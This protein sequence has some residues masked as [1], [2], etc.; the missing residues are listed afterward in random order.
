MAYGFIRTTVQTRSKG[1][2]ATGALCYRLGLAA[3]STIL[4]KDGEPRHFDFTRRTGIAATGYAAPPGTD[5]SWRDPLRWAKRIEAVDR[6]RNS[7]QFRDDVVA[8]PVELVEAGMAEEAVQ[9]YADRLAAEHRTVVHFAIHEPD[10]GGLNHHAHVLYP[11]RHVVGVTFAKKRDREQDNPKPGEPDLITRHKAIWSEICR[12][13]GVELRWSSPTPGHHLGPKLCAVKRARLVE[14]TQESVRETIAVSKP[15]EIAPDD[16]ALR[17]VAVIATGVNEGLTVGA[18]LRREL[19]QIRRGHPAPRPV[20]APTGWL[21]EVLQPA[22]VPEVLPARGKAPEV[23]PPA[24]AHEVLPPTRPSPEVLSARTGAPEVLPPTVA[25]EVLPRTSIPEV[26]PP[27]RKAARVLHPVRLPEVLPVVRS[28]AAVS[29]PRAVAEAMVVTRAEERFP[30]E[31]A[32]TW[33]EVER[34]LERQRQTQVH[35]HARATAK[36]LCDRAK[37]RERA[38]SRPPRAAFFGRIQEI[39]G[40]L[41]KCAREVLKRLGLSPSS[42]PERKAMQTPGRPEAGTAMSSRAAKPAGTEPSRWERYEARWPDNSPADETTFTE[43]TQPPPPDGLGGSS[44]GIDGWRRMLGSMFHS[45]EPKPLPRSLGPAGQ[46]RTDAARDAASYAASLPSRYRERVDQERIVERSLEAEEKVQQT[47]RYRFASERK[48][49]TV[50]DDAVRN[51]CAADAQ[52]L[53]REMHVE[54]DRWRH[55]WD[56][57]VR[58]DAM[59]REEKQ[60]SDLRHLRESLEEHGRGRSEYRGS[61]RTV[62]RW[63]R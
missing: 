2:T 22:R 4:G 55:H 23:L 19:Q 15:G 62:S 48:R 52:R 28:Q 29:A 49:T 9:A 39:A 44:R 36:K 45:G 51:A 37:R 25:P 24:G 14:E 6:R 43:L 32:A 63:G 34:E 17:A 26:L 33:L 38:T 20:V 57:L 59:L 41:L 56:V 50:Q 7:R 12:A 3:V 21:P 16:R 35:E 18:M 13:R 54:R 40:W 30:Q 10:R 5:P 46:A 11:G 31:T 1:H 61:D 42:A 8:I 27:T 60:E 58:H 47:L 53:D